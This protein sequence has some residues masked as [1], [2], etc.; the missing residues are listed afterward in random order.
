M[1]P[2]WFLAWSIPLCVI[3]AFIL[4]G[5]LYR[6]DD[7]DTRRAELAER[8]SREWQSAAYNFASNQEDADTYHTIED[9]HA[10][11]RREAGL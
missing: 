11:E 10:S 9:R 1:M 6:C 2:I 8:Q 5:L 7:E 3:V 4:F